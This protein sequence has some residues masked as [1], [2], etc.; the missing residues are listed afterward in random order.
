MIIF[1]SILH[2]FQASSYVLLHQ[3]IAAILCLD[4][5]GNSYFTMQTQRED[6]LLFSQPDQVAKLE[7]A[8]SISYP[9]ATSIF[10]QYSIF[11]YFIYIH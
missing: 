9:E 10:I 2:F 5:K 3:I 11:H 7:R 6:F 4:I 8:S 1:S